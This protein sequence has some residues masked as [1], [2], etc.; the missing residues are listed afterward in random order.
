MKKL[1]I[2]FIFIVLLSSCTSKE[3]TI[4]LTPGIDTVAQFSEYKPSTCK[5]VTSKRTY[6]MK[7]TE[8][9]VDTRLE[10]TYT[11]EYSY[12]HEET[13]YTC[14][15]KVFVTD[16]TPPVVTLI[17]GVDTV[18]KN[19]EWVDMS[20]EYF[21]ENYKILEVTVDNPVDTSI[22]GTYVVT[23]TVTDAN[24]NE[25]YAYRYVTVVEN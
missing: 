16:E 25:G 1:I 4:V 10:G 18:V 23:Y 7:V 2:V 6:L 19:S 5:L 13:L 21:D 17:P 3:P 9:D 15:R 12:T 11:V 14:Q 8:N 24:G 20:A 22:I